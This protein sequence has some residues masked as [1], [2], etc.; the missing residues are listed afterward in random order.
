MERVFDAVR[1]CLLFNRLPVMRKHYIAIKSQIHPHTKQEHEEFAFFTTEYQKYYKKAYRLMNWRALVYLFLY[2][3]ITVNILRLIPHLGLLVNF[4]EL[5]GSLLSGG[6]ALFLIFVLTYIVIC[7]LVIMY[8][9]GIVITPGAGSPNVVKTGIISLS[10]I[11]AG[12][13]VYINGTIYP[14]KTPTVI[15]K[16]PPGECTVKLILKD[17]MSWQRNVAVIEEKATVLEN[18]LLVPAHWKTATI[19]SPSGFQGLLVFPGNTYLL[20]EHGKQLKDI[21]IYLW[22]EGFKALISQESSARKSTNLHPLLA[23][24]SPFLEATLINVYSIE[25]SPLLLLYVEFNGDKKFLWID[26]VYGTTK[27][28]DITELLPALPENI[29]WDPQDSKNL[30]TLQDASLNRI[31]LGLKIVY[32]QI[33]NHVQTFGLHNQNIYILKQNFVFERYDRDGTRQQAPVDDP[34]LTESLFKD[35]KPIKI[36]VLS[37]DLILFLTDR[38]ELICNRL[39]YRLVEN[40]VKGFKFDRKN[41]LLLWTDHAVGWIDFTRKNE[42]STFEIGPSVTWVVTDA[43]HVE[44]AFWANN[45]NYILY[46]DRAAVMLTEKG[47]YGPPAPATFITAIKKD[48]SV[49]FSDKMGELLFLKEPEGYLT[50]LEILPNPSL[51]PASNKEN[52]EKSSK[53]KTEGTAP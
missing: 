24:D 23:P 15:N 21:F 34:Q 17:Y 14:Q 6:I 13:T 32:P 45:G 16:L 9:L 4:V 51:L 11:P 29:L 8:A 28:E 52:K 40:E 49:A 47:L 20:L 22:D 18:I 10:S 12:A 39:P 50:A 44:D 38:G 43:A 48:S 3:T 53:P 7:P 36:S 25:N 31:N 41:E 27:V 33:I 42:S 1:K 5:G 30:F 35:K 26:P 37:E 19:S 2:A 46:V